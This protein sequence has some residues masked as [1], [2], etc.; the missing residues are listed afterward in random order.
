[1]R[2]VNTCCHRSTRRRGRLSAP[3]LCGA[4]S[5]FFAAAGVANAAST[6]QPG[7]KSNYQGS[8]DFKGQKQGKKTSQPQA[9]DALV[10]NFEDL[11]RHKKAGTYQFYL[12][13][14]AGDKLVAFEEYQKSRDL[15]AVSDK[16]FKLAFAAA[17]RAT[18]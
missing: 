6:Q 11:L 9:D 8:L 13:L 16:V 17:R 18:Q 1:M 7:G 2:S 14:D 5:L 4:L 10:R 3:A 15:S 12:K